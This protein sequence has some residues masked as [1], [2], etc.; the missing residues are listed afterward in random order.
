MKYLKYPQRVKTGQNTPFFDLW[1]RLGLGKHILP[2]DF[3]CKTICEH[4][5]SQ[6]VQV[7]FQYV[8]AL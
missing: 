2:F 1:F 4:T 8:L 7:T 5:N 6:H 3:I